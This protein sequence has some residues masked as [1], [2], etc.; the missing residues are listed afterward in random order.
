MKKF[1]FVQPTDGRNPPDPDTGLKLVA[2]G[3][4]VAR[5]EYWSR[6]IAD[7]SVKMLGDADAVPADRAAPKVEAAKPAMEKKMAKPAA[8]EKPIDN[9]PASSGSKGA[10]K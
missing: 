10:D 6:R 8:S 2:G 7:G 1:L 9:E 3:K 4:W 5:N